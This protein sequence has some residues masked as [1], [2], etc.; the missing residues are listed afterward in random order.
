M[1]ANKNLIGDVRNM[2]AIYVDKEV[3]VDEDLVTARSSDLCNIFVRR[4][5]DLLDQK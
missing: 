1:V 4:I 3:V 2:G 5:I